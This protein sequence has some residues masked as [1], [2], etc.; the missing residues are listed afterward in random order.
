MVCK[1]KHTFSDLMFNIFYIAYENPLL[2]QR[3]FVMLC[4]SKMRA[5]VHSCFCSASKQITYNVILFYSQKSKV[6]L[7]ELLLHSYF[8]NDF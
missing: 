3:H 8:G 4:N 6:K 1:G 7:V 5:S 2:K